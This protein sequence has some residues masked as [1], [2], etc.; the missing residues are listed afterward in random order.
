MEVCGYAFVGVV[1]TWED[2]LRLI[3]DGRAH[4]VVVASRSH[5]P[6]DRRPRIEA[7]ADAVRA[8]GPGSHCVA[9][10]EASAPRSRRARRVR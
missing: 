8:D 10:P 5:L 9:P 7:V 1:R 2:A 3:R 6:H 4:V